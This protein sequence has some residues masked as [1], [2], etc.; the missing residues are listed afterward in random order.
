MSHLDTFAALDARLMRNDKPR[1]LTQAGQHPPNQ[2]EEHDMAATR[3]TALKLKGLDHPRTPSQVN[4][5]L[6]R[7]AAGLDHH[8]PTAAHPYARCFSKA[9]HTHYGLHTIT[10]GS[11]SG[12]HVKSYGPPITCEQY[13]LGREALKNTGL[14][15]LAA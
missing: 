3:K 7:I 13:V 8:E 14:T 4:K 15:G 11:G 2:N 12:L 10:H 1:P 5:R 6:D 9:T